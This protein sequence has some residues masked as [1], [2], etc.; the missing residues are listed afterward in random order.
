MQKVSRVLFLVPLGI[1]AWCLHY[2]IKEPQVPHEREPAFVRG[3]EIFQT[4]HSQFCFVLLCANVKT[5]YP[6]LVLINN[7]QAIHAGKISYNTIVMTN[8][9]VEQAAGDL[10]GRFGATLYSLPAKEMFTTRYSVQNQDTHKR[11]RIMWNK[12]HAWNLTNCDKVISLDVDMVVIQPIHELFTIEGEF[13]GVPVAY[14]D[15]KIAFWNPPGPFEAKVTE[16]DTWGNFSKLSHDLNDGEGL[17]G[18]LMVL[19]PSKETLKDLVLAAGHLSHRTCCPTQ[20]FLYR[21]FELQGKY[22]RLP[23]TYNTRKY[24]R[25][26]LA[27]R[28]SMSSVKVY[29][30][31]ERQKPWLLGRKES[32]LNHFAA[33][34]WEGADGLES[35]CAHLLQDSLELQETLVMVRHEAILYSKSK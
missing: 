26:D 16:P 2:F 29:H 32:S 7:I 18:G 22:T 9:I 4:N 3:K 10:F 13:A 33:L 31:V 27:R 12:L 34:W 14:A 24:H 35:I 5:I 19:V 11:D 25:I 28:P 8:A 6:A 17:N 1:F 23:L 15:E 21:F 20:E 30:F